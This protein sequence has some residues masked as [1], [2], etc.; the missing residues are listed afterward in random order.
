MKKLLVLFSLV[1]FLAPVY[2]VKAEDFKITDLSPRK[3][4]IGDKISILGQEFTSLYIKEIYFGDVKVNQESF[5]IINDGKIEVVVP[6]GTIGGI[7]TIIAEEEL[8]RREGLGL[9][10]KRYSS[11]FMFAVAK[12]VIKSISPTSGKVGTEVSITGDYIQSNTR[13]TVV[14]FAGN[15]A[16]TVSITKTNNTESV[17]KAKIPLRAETSPLELNTIPEKEGEVSVAIKIGDQTAL[18]PAG[19]TI[20]ASEV[21]SN[22]QSGGTLREGSGN[23]NISEVTPASTSTGKKINFKGLVPVCNTKIDVQS[24]G[25]SDAC[26]FDYFMA[27]INNLID[28]IVKYLATPIFAILFVYAGVLYITSGGNSKST[29]KAKKILINSLIG[30]LIILASWLIINT[31]LTSLGYTGPNFLAN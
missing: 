4:L 2:F 16:E 8:E 1:L 11:P 12:P 22:Q 23:S 30:Y 17:V 15:R 31:I 24:G 25:F 20:L 21:T 14:Y 9:T 10:P 3:A 27:L 13:D 26:D 29:D 5:S 18:S 7:V 6:T 19:F 28:Y